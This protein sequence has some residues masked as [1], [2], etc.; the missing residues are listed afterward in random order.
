MD[1]AIQKAS[2]P[3]IHGGIQGTGNIQVHDY[4]Q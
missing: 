4:A 1:R 3:G 2:A